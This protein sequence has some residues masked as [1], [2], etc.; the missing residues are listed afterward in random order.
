ML[1]LGG[2]SRIL[3]IGAYIELNA[4]RTEARAFLVVKFVKNQNF[5]QKTEISQFKGKRTQ[6]TPV[7]GPAPELHGIGSEISGHKDNKLFIYVIHNFLKP[8]S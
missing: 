8:S 4:E 7:L 2:R 3:G 6:G 1:T 5:M